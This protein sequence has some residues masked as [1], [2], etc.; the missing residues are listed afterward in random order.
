M[1][2]AKKASKEMIAAGGKPEA[3]RQGGARSHDAEAVTSD[4]ELI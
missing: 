4:F 3:K 1:S 2:R